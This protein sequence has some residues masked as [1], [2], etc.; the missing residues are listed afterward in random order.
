MEINGSTADREAA[1]DPELT[2]GT[3]SSLSA[4]P[5]TTILGTTEIEITTMEAVE[6]DL[7]EE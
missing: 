7:T 5:T 3:I 4:I 1:T 2:H 6:G